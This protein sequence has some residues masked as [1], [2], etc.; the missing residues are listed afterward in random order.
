MRE[1]QD[2]CICRKKKKT[3]KTPLWKV[4]YVRHLQ[5]KQGQITLFLRINKHLAHKNQK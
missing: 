3:W 5:K 4:N 1:S 2:S